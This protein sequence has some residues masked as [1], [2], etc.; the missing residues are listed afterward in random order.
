MQGGKK[1][2]TNFINIRN[3]TGENTDLQTLKG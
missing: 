2:K 1:N 3:K